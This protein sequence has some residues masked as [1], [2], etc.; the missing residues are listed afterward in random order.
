MTVWMCGMACAVCVS[1]ALY[2]LYRTRKLQKQIREMSVK[3]EEILDR[4]TDEKVMLF[5]D[6]PEVIGLLTQ[7][8]RMLGDRQ[9]QKAEYLRTE[10]ASGRMLSN[11]SHDLKTPLTVILGYLE[12]L[13][14]DETWKENRMLQKVE[15]KAEQV[16]EL[17]TQFFTLA[18]IEAGDMELTNRKLDVCEVCRR[19]LLDFYDILMEQE[20]QVEP[21]IPEE[22]V[23]F[24]GDEQALDRILF[25]LLSNG[26]RYGGDGKYLG[27][28]VEKK[29]GTVEIR[30]TDH[31]RG[32]EAEHLKYIFRR[33]YTPEDSRSRG[34]GGSGIGLAIVKTLTER[35]G[36]QVFAESTPGAETVFTV[37]LPDKMP[38]E[39]NS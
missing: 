21:R 34:T 4:N 39:R 37:R 19:N 27:L 28:S 15:T 17:I 35:M 8:N 12:I 13:C 16:M 18:K 6:E 2:A 11:I 23:F 10:A 9:R 22:P 31:G 36:G 3:L 20:F 26:V 7:I 30:V 5:T 25:N 1:A 24:Y 14:M 29:A 33:L 38:K 32:I